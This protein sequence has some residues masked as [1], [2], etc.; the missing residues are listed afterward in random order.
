MVQRRF[1]TQ[2]H[3]D[4][5][6]DKPIRTWYNNFEQTG[7]MDEDNRIR[8]CNKWHLPVAA[9]NWMNC[10][11]GADHLNYVIKS[12]YYCFHIDCKYFFCLALVANATAIVAKLLRNIR[13]CFTEKVKTNAKISQMIQQKLCIQNW[14]VNVFPLDVKIA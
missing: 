5:P 2:Y 4:P 8:N 11:M 6:T 7:S 1:R 3:K 12:R 9:A 10:A 14:V 13:H